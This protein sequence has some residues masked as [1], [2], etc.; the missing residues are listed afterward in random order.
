MPE[1]SPVA[2]SVAPSGDS[3]SARGI[4]AGVYE[5]SEPTAGNG[6]RANVSMSARSFVSITEIESRSA[7]TT[8]SRVPSADSAIDDEWPG[9]GGG[10]DASGGASG[11]TNAGG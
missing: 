2:Y 7:L 10:P 9:V 1:R 3:A 6:A 8:Y 5:P 11:G 4:T